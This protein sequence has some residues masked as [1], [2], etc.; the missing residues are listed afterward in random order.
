MFTMSGLMNSLTTIKC[1]HSLSLSNAKL[2]VP[3]QRLE[4]TFSGQ[5]VLH[6]LLRRKEALGH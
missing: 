3:A 4:K 1:K 6:D 5:H 2:W